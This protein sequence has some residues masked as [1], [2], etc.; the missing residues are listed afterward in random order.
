MRRGVRTQMLTPVMRRLG[1]F[2]SHRT[3]VFEVQN[4]REKKKITLEWDKRAR[5]RAR[6][7]AERRIRLPIRPRLASEMWSRSPQNPA[8]RENGKENA[9]IFL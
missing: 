6:A 4:V 9:I 3:A 5:E 8:M 1:S 2:V 7:D